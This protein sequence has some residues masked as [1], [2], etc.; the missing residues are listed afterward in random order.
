MS[1]NKNEKQIVNSMKKVHND[2]INELVEHYT[3]DMDYVKKIID[4]TTRLLER[5]K[6]SFYSD[7]YHTLKEE[8]PDEFKDLRGDPKELGKFIV[9]VVS[10]RHNR[11]YVS[12]NK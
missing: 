5:N 2:V 7:V 3:E 10:N 12:K 4:D 6:E 8:F 11:D 9:K 1:W